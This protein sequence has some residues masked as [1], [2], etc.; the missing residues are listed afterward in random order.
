MVTCIPLK[1]AFYAFSVLC[2]Y[3]KDLDEMRLMCKM[4]SPLLFQAAKSNYSKHG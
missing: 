1:L 2:K 3:D 4:T